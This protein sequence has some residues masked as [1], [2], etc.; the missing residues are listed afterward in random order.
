M[1]NVP[2]GIDWPE[3]FRR[4]K[5]I[6]QGCFAKHGVKPVVFQVLGETA[7]AVAT[8]CVVMAFAISGE[9]LGEIDVDG[10]PV[11]YVHVPAI[12]LPGIQKTIKDRAA[13]SSIVAQPDGTFT[14]IVVVPNAEVPK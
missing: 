8:D 13:L 12:F 4:R 3:L 14:G 1:D 6:Q 9:N 7:Y 2:L 11:S 10:T 5:Q